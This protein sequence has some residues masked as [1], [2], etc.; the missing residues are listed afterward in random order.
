M[1]KASKEIFVVFEK[2]VKPVN[3]ADRSNENK[4]LINFL[5]DTSR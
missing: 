2:K 1:D 4:D 5:N 3:T